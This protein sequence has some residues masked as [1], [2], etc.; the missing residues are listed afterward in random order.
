M[1]TLRI[2]DS[3]WH[4]L[5]WTLPTALLV[6]TI[7]LWG[8]AFFMEK[9]S[10]WSVE[11]PPIDA[12]LIELPVPAVT[13]NVQTKRPAA[14]HQPKSQPKPLPLV[15]PQQAPVMPQVIPRTEKA[16]A[17]Q[18]PATQN[19]EVT[20]NAIQ[21]QRQATALGNTSTNNG[22]QT[23][24]YNGK[25]SQDN[26][27]ANSGARAISR[28]MPQI[29]DDLRNIAFKFSARARFNIAADGSVKVELIKPTPN[30][31]LNRILLD[32][33]KKW[34]FIPAIKNGNPVASAPEI[35]V[36]MEVN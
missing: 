12:Q 28:P 24:S 18:T 19:P 20:T 35:D 4:R 33:L 2:I 32:S 1:R 11:P 27:Y 21:N 9:P 26:M 5:P 16:P 31:R 7:A 14:V 13:Q 23:A 29:P 8:L 10:H 17:A 15:R 6:W 25:G 36:K 3:P 30:P 34:R 22:T